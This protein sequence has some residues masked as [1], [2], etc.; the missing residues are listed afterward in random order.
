ML[1][2]LLSN[3]LYIVDLFWVDHILYTPMEKV[4]MDEIFMSG[5]PVATPPATNEEDNSAQR[6][7]M[8]V[9]MIV[10][11]SGSM[12]GA[13]IG[14]VNQAI[15]ETLPELENVQKMQPGVEIRLALMSFNSKAQWI[16]TLPEPVDKFTFAN[17]TTGGGTNAAHAFE[18]L[19]EKLS[20]KSFMNAA[21]GHFAP[22]ILFL[23]DG[24]S[25]SGWESKLANLRENLWY[26]CATK[27]AI[28]AGEEATT[29]EAMR[30]FREFTK[31]SEMI[32]YAD[33]P[34]KIKD[35]IILVSAHASKWN[36]SHRTPGIDSGNDANEASKGEPQNPLSPD[37]QNRTPDWW[38]DIKQ[39][40]DFPSIPPVN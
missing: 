1:G 23:S 30:L 6:R 7:V 32:I 18:L 21:G 11:T 29:D 5:D 4:A 3:S 15:R 19:L 27:V 35:F 28:A 37:M 34:D 16:T 17:F 10:D 9:F 40:V 24:E 38:K 39:K 25:M 31:N 13:R 20:R 22:L 8:N 12:A 36:S 14:S 2:Q 33:Q 26:A